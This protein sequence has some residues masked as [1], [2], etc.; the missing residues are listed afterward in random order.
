MNL[1]MSFNEYGILLET[2]GLLSTTSPNRPWCCNVPWCSSQR[3]RP[4]DEQPV[5]LESQYGCVAMLFL[6]ISLPHGS[7][8]CCE[9][10]GKL[11]CRELPNSVRALPGQ[12]RPTVQKT[13][14][15]LFGHGAVRMCVAEDALPVLEVCLQRR[16][17]RWLMAFAQHCQVAVLQVK[18][19]M[20]RQSQAKQ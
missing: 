18:D 5:V 17:G 3:E 11:L 4:V 14:E 19:K 9:P 13:Q 12:D 8:L 7:H 2:A 20:P 15:E 16:V 10:F 1:K 6:A